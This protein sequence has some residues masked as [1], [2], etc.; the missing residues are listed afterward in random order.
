MN[1]WV[2]ISIGVF[3]LAILFSAGVL[4]VYLGNRY[5]NA[6]TISFQIQT[7]CQRFPIL[8]IA[9]AWLLFHLT[10]VPCKPE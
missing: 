3:I 5:G 1:T 8:Y 2:S 4:D 10:K 6:S 7:W 9:L